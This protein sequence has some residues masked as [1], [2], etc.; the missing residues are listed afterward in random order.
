MGWKGV[1]RSIGAAARAAERDAKRRQRQLELQAKH[2]SKM[3]ALEM[4]AYEYEVFSNRIDLLKSV[5]KESGDSIDWLATMELPAPS[6]PLS[7][8]SNELDAQRAL[9]T[10]KPSLLDRALGRE[11]KIR[12]ELTRAIVL[13]RERDLLNSAPTLSI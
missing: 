3:E 2:Y 1:V 11:T 5:H 13:A 7:S 12:D 8:N 6:Q 9:D 10:Y 4:A